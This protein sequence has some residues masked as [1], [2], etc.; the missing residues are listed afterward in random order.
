MVSNSDGD[1]WHT[2]SRAH[3]SNEIQAQNHPDD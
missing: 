3:C 2:N 1:S